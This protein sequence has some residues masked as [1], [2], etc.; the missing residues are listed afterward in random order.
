MVSECSN[1]GEE[2]KLDDRFCPNCGY[3]V[4]EE[5]R[6]GEDWGTGAQY[7][8]SDRKVRKVRET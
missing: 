6:T 7:T 1:C 5:T 3:K 8:H 2:V 4:E